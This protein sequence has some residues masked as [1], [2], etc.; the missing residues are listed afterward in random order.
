[1][2]SCF[3]YLFS[4]VYMGSAFLFLSTANGKYIYVQDEGQKSKTAGIFSYIGYLL[5]F[6][7]LP[8]NIQNSKPTFNNAYAKHHGIPVTLF[9]KFDKMLGIPIL[10]QS[11]VG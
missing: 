3:I 6:K 2:C 5:M 10:K 4:M 7:N 11:V 9:Q 1:M 8:Y